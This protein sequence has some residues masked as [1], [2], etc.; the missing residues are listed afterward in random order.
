M[1]WEPVFLVSFC[2]LRICKHSL[3]YR[4]NFQSD[5]QYIK[6]PLFQSEYLKG[7][8]WS[9]NSN[10]W[11]VFV[12]SWSTSIYLL[13]TKI[14]SLWLIISKLFDSRH[15]IWN[16]QIGLRTKIFGQIFYFNDLEAFTY[17]SRKLQVWHSL[18]ENWSISVRIFGGDRLV[19]E[20]EFL[21]SFCIVRISK[22][23]LTYYENFQ[24]EAHFV[25]IGLFKSEYLKE[26][27]WS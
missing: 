3:T 19:W 26:S 24:C 25:K 9:Y 23:L 14:S 27:D 20:L 7:G 17:L 6:I 11:S 10:F 5:S 16:S 4:E 21:F 13:I 18:Y 1:V 15:N 22:D 12:F 8:D 2:V